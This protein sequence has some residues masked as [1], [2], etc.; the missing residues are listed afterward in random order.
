MNI[1]KIKQI[2]W[3][4]VPYQCRE[5]LESIRFSF[6]KKKILNE[7]DANIKSADNPQS[8]Q[9]I[10][11]RIFKTKKLSVYNYDYTD[12]Y[13]VHNYL[14]DL[15][16]DQKHQMFYAVRNSRKLYITRTYN[17]LETS[18]LCYKNICLEQDENSPHR[19]LS[20]RFP[21]TKGGI[22]VDIGAA[23]G[24]F[25]LDHLDYFEKIYLLECDTS[26]IDALNITFQQQINKKVFIVPKFASDVNDSNNITIDKLL[27]HENIGKLTI[28]MDVEGAEAKVL[29]GCQTSFKKANEIAAFIT[30]YHRPYDSVELLNYLDGFSYEYSEGY[31]INLHEKPMKKPYLRKGVIRA[32]KHN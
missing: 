6:H 12:N 1:I 20:E 9:Q 32:Y 30:S 13:S 28:K 4:V 18:A 11:D 24:F 17:T 27:E 14:Q 31:M 8:Y 22:L 16:Y 15:H 3:K 23:E 5:Q 26:W 21:T 25:A 29:A 2:Y 10:K 19:Y 7:L